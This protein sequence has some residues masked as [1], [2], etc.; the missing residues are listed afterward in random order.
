MDFH[1]LLF[2]MSLVRRY[3]R[4]SGD[5]V[6]NLTRVV[7]IK[8]D[9]YRLRFVYPLTNHFYGGGSTMLADNSE[10]HV[11]SFNSSAESETELQSIMDSLDKY[12]S[13]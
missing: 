3:F 11:I 6:I 7:S 10:A 4:A 12:Y 9:G 13:K 5:M 2:K 8:K 1:R